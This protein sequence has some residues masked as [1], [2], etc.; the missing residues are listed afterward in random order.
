[1]RW[2]RASTK[3]NERERKSNY[4]KN[5]LNGDEFIE[6]EPEVQKKNHFISHKTEK[7][8]LF[9]I[10]ILRSNQNKSVEKLLGEITRGESTS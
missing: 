2:R 10:A 7:T 1:M 6:L 5:E 4:I 8:N 3:S 9:H